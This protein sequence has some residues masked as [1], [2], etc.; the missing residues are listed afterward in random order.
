MEQRLSLVTLG[1][2]SR[3]LDPLLSSARLGA[4]ASSVEGEVAFYQAGGLVVG[5][6]SRTA[7]AAD[8]GL[9]TAADGRCDPRAQR[10]HS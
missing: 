4:H 9:P 10:Q 3:P 1:G 8:S 2:G 7:L 5:L 6:W